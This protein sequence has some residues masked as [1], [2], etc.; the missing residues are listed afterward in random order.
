MSGQSKGSRNWPHLQ[1]CISQQKRLVD[2]LSVIQSWCPHLFSFRWQELNPA[3]SPAT[4]ASQTRAWLSYVFMA[5]PWHFACY[6]FSV[7]QQV[8]LSTPSACVL[9]FIYTW[10]ADLEKWAVC[11]NKEVSPVRFILGVVFILLREKNVNF[12]KASLPAF[13]L[14]T[15][16]QSDHKGFNVL[17]KCLNLG[18]HLKLFLFL[19]G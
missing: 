10:V 18:R 9:C 3:C 11:V 16:S 1:Y 6:T 19:M 4:E 8:N 17:V 5:S 7:E 12:F 2:H 13:W 15:A 14:L